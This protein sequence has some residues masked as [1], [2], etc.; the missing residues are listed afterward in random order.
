M[1]RFIADLVSVWWRHPTTTVVWKFT[2]TATAAD[3]VYYLNFAAGSRGS[4]GTTPIV[5]RPSN[6]N[7]QHRGAVDGETWIDRQ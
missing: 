1:L 5:Q 4:F 3:S 7:E 6:W 2:F